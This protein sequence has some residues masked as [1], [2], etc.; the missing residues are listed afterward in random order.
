VKG[1]KAQGRCLFPPIATLANLETA[2][3]RLNLNRDRETFSNMGEELEKRGAAVDINGLTDHGAR[4]I[5]TQEES[6]LGNL[7]GGLPAT[8]E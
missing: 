2:A 5:R 7:H 1:S 8:L 3:H 6:D 4:H